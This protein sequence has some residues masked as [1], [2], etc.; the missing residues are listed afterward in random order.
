MSTPDTPPVMLLEDVRCEAGGGTV[1]QI[2]RL[3]VARGERIVVIGSNGAG[4]STLLRL[5]GG[6]QHPAQGR[7]EIL[8]RRLDHG[9]RARD[10]RHLRREVGQ[11][12]QGLHL[13]KQ[14]TALDVMLQ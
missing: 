7:V 14:L 12:F 4:K 8:E 5:L 3:V 13:V 9:M 1:L 6:F 11:V 2:D 10:L